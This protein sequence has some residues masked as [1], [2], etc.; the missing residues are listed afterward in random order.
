VWK[1]VVR[2]KGIEN[3]PVKIAESSNVVWIEEL[4]AK[5][6][7]TGFVIQLGVTEIEELEGQYDETL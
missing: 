4:V 2:F 7:E 3:K 1:V 5:L 6:L